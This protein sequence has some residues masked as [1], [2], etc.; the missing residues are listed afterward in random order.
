M[1]IANWNNKNLQQLKKYIP[2]R[3]YAT[4]IHTHTH[5]HQST[6]KTRNHFHQAELTMHTIKAGQRGADFISTLRPLSH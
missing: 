6:T 1:V 4:S 2:A 3:L 5:T